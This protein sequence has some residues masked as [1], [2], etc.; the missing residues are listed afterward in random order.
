M[1][2]ERLFRTPEQFAAMMSRQL[3]ENLQMRVGQREGEP[4]MLEIEVHADKPEE[5]LQVSLHDTYRLY[6]ASGDLKVAVDYLN[7]IVRNSRFVNAGNGF[8]R[9]DPAY[10]YPAIR[11]ARY[12]EEAGRDMAFV[13]DKYLPGLRQIY[14]EIKD[15]CTKIVTES[16]LACNPLLTE[17]EVRSLA[18]R[19]LRRRGW[20][21]PSISMR[22]PLRISCSVDIYLNPPYPAEC[23]FLFSELVARR[24]PSSYI[25]AFTNRQCTLVMRSQEPM[26]T[27]QQ[28][29]ELVRESEF[30]ALVRRSCRFMPHPVSD[31]LYWVR[32][33]QASLLGGNFEMI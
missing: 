25:I 5:K 16:L 15:G 32:N 17:A 11:D 28:A 6:Q 19:N 1:K 20:K 29:L 21:R 31:R 26:D 30:Q 33:G 13:S 14:L 10:I 9:L 8:M 7:D 3:R 24:M 18:F 4:L 23:Q 2:A 22:N 27:A 12:V